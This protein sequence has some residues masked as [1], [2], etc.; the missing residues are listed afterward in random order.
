MKKKIKVLFVLFC[1]IL[2]LNAFCDAVIIDHNCTDIS[3]IPKDYIQKASKNFKVAYGHTSHGSQIVSGMNAL[4]KNDPDLFA[5]GKN[6]NDKKLLFLDS[7]PSGDLGNPDRTTWAQRTRDFLQNQGK[8]I[9]LIM[10]SWCGQAN[11]SE[12]DIQTYLNLMTDLE[13]EF[14]NVKFVYMTGHLNGSGK[15]GN[16]NQRNE[17]IRNYCKQNKK[18]LF[19]FADIESYDP[20]G[21]VNYMELNA[22]DACDY[23]DDK[24]RKNWAAEWL[25]A[26]PD[27]K[28]ALPSS[29]AHS[30]PLNAALK[31]RAFWWM[32][33]QLSGWKPQK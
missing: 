21:K 17:Q 13:K 20:D 24:G 26:N 22:T 5:F 7:Q 28:I 3:K 18:I 23:K 19:D 10:W 11:G 1:G 9:N 29:A 14:P 2:S 8:N 30:H 6:E 25:K 16:L 4:Q 15:N 33:A 31:G 32:L 12:K 27:N